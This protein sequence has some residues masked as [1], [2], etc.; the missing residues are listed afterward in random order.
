MTQS[1]MIENALPRRLPAGGTLLVKSRET[2]VREDLPAW[3]RLV[4]HAIEAERD[5]E[6]GYRHFL[7]RKKADDQ[8]L[9]GDLAKEAMER[10]QGLIH[11]RVAKQ[12]AQRRDALV[13]DAIRSLV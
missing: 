12:F 8:A 5:A 11:D 1:E 9:A 2:S 7:L 6:H 4:G 3:C 10:L 13:A